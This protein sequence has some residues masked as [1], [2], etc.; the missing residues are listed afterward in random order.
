MIKVVNKKYLRLEVWPSFGY[1]VFMLR[2]KKHCGLIGAIVATL[3]VFG[4][5]YYFW[6]NSTTRRLAKIG[7]KKDE[8]ALIR[9]KISQDYLE[10]IFSYEYLPEL[11]EILA[12]REKPADFRIEKLSDYVL[13]L[14]K[15]DFEPEK[16]VMLVNHTDYN[17]DETYTPEKI[18][19][20]YDEY[21]LTPNLER[22]FRFLD[23]GSAEG[24]KTEELVALVNANR[25]R[26]Y[27]TETEPARLENGSLT[28][29]NKY[30]Y[31]DQDFSVETVEQDARYGSVGEKMEVET[32]AAFEKMFQAA[33]DDGYQL[34]VTSGYRGYDEQEEVFASYLAEGGEDHALKYAA[35]PGYS[36]H[37][38]GRAIDVFTP[39]ETTSS[40]AGTPVAKW[41][42]ENAHLYGFI[43]RYPEGKE[44]LTGYI[45][46]PWHYRYV[47]LE[48]AQEIKSRGITLEEYVAAFGS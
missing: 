41:L 42:E 13:M 27:Y 11:V 38:T 23:A 34:Y 40:F 47:G 31:L 43:L 24:L 33:Y 20:L 46:E 22:Y 30:Y 39:G 10:M 25:D 6:T 14:Q 37:Q 26:E 36:E 9:E 4:V 12:E 3:L 16:T 7:Y 15:Y 35:K 17:I 21:Y 8:I 18:Q 5:G 29:V 28:L 19:I 44:N 1:N 32:Y 48:A 2:R 45:Y